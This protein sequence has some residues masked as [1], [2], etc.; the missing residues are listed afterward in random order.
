MQEGHEVSNPFT[1]AGFS[2]LSLLMFPFF[3][4]LPSFCL[5]SRYPL[6]L[7]A[8]SLLLIDLKNHQ[9]IC[10][11][12]SLSG[13]LGYPQLCS[14]RLDSRNLACQVDKSTNRSFLMKPHDNSHPS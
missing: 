12:F 1:F 5:Y 6:H 3:F 9:Y 10:Y 13:Q 14:R 11:H 7:L 4:S 2:R 8:V